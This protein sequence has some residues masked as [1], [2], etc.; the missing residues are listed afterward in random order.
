MCIIDNCIGGVWN[1]ESASGAMRCVERINS[2]LRTESQYISSPADFTNV[3]YPSLCVVAYS[4]ISLSLSFSFPPSS[5]S[6]NSE[7]SSSSY[8]EK[9]SRSQHSSSA[10]PKLTS[11]AIRVSRMRPKMYNRNISGINIAISNIKKSLD[12]DDRNA[13]IRELLKD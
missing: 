6:S 4:S 9:S 10:L 5:S 8:S 1:I 12:V 13:A 11:V 7:K 2:G 3:F